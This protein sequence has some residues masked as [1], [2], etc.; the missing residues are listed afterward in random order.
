MASRTKAQSP[1]ASA[2]KRPDKVVLYV[3]ISG[4]QQR[5]L[6]VQA[7]M[8]DVPLA[9]LV[10]EAIDDYLAAKGPTA[11]DVENFVKLVRKSVQAGVKTVKG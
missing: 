4:E 3:L 6:R 2:R 8:R 5:A 1:S 9:D 11:E 10:R 7:F